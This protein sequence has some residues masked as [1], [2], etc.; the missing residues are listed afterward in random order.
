MQNFSGIKLCSVNWMA[1]FVGAR[2]LTSINAR[3]TG[4]ATRFAVYWTGL[5]ENLNIVN[6]LDPKS[7]VLV[8]YLVVHCKPVNVHVHE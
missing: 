7:Y 2:L 1:E 8:M 4:E 6:F 5:R 3:H